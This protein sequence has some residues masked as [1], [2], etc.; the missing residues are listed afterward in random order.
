MAKF[1]EP[2]E[3]K[4]PEKKMKSPWNFSAPEYDERSSVFVS[5]GTNFGT[6]FKQPVG[7][8]GNPSVRKDRTIP[9]G[10]FSFDAEQPNDKFANKEIE[11]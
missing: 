6:G 3:P 10:T 8:K 1:K 7:N 4:A 5:A 2:L 11:L 9:K